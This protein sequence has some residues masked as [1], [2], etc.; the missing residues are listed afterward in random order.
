M[1]GVPPTNTDVA[2]K[3]ELALEISLGCIALVSACPITGIAANAAKAVAT[4]ANFINLFTFVSSIILTA[5][6]IYPLCLDVNERAEAP[7]TLRLQHVARRRICPLR[8]PPREKQSGVCRAQI[9]LYAVSKDRPCSGNCM[10]KPCALASS[11]TRPIDFSTPFT[12]LT[13]VEMT[14]DGGLRVR[15]DNY[16][17]RIGRSE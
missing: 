12:L 14:M 2:E 3:L 13:S 15:P 4:M 6:C 16:R 5:Q 10:K 8:P 11:R 1:I 17:C 7:R 9:E